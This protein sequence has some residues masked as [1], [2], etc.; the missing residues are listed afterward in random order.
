MDPVVNQT[1]LENWRTIDK[2]EETTLDAQIYK[3]MENTKLFT[4]MGK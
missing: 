3:K 2:R 1:W 4:F